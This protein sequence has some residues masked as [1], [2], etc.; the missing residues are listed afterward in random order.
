MA[1]D[2]ARQLLQQ[3]IAA[4][5]AGQ[6]TQAQQL[7]REAVKRDPRS[8]IAWLWLSSVTPDPK[9]R[10]FCFQQ[11]LN[12]NPRNEQALAGIKQLSAASTSPVAP[13]PAAPPTPPSAPFVTPAAPPTGPTATSSAPPAASGGIPVIDDRRLSASMAQLDPIVLNYQPVPATPL[14]F[15]WEH[16]KRGRVGDSSA[17]LLR[18]AV[19]VGVLVVLGA[20]GFGGYTVITHLPGAAVAQNNTPTHTPSP[21]RSPTPTPGPTDTPSMTPRV[22]PTAMPSYPASIQRGDYNAWAPTDVYPSAGGGRDSVSANVEIAN[23]QYADAIPKLQN[24]MKQYSTAKDSTYDGAVFQLVAALIGNKQVADAAALVNE[25]NNRSDSAVFAAAQA[26][27]ALA[28]GNYDQAAALATQA[29][30]KAKDNKLI[31][32]YYILAQANIGRK[33]YDPAKVAATS[34]LQQQPDN[35]LLLLTRAQAFILSGAP[36]KAEADAEE[37]LYIDPRNRDAYAM[38]CQA[39]LARA[40]RTADHD[41]QVQLYGAAVLAAKD[42]LFRFPG[43]TLAWLLLGK[44]RQGEGNLDQAITAY[45]QAIVVDKTSPTAQQVFIALGNIY[46][47]EHQYSNAFDNFDS[48]LT[49]G[50]DDSA[51]SG[52]FTAALALKKFDAALTDVNSLVKGAPDNKSL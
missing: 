27:V 10:L 37:S 41:G 32:A 17:L 43:D 44:A 1:S 11:V 38:R 47:D 52:H 34:G 50:D 20:I 15:R 48:A 36:E 3:G 5:K 46:L 26:N 14:P 31:A 39:R 16:K 13:P 45:M 9:E 30:N 35:V 24:I 42:Y 49:I 4:A 51:R 21:T 23:G 25:P 12:I 19:V 22:P 33:Q 40:S 7:L 28:Q 6:Q 8:E 18:T 2:Q 29:I